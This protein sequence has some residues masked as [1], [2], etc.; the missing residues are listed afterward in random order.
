MKKTYVQPTTDIVNM[1]LPHLLVS[2]STDNSHGRIPIYDEDEDYL[3]E[4]GEHQYPD[5]AW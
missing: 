2:F 4:K 1:D 5:Y 3:D